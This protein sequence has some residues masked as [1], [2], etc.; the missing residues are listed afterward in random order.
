MKERKELKFVNKSENENPLFADNGSSGFDLRAWITKDDERSL[1]G[2]NGSYYIILPPLGRRMI[3]TGLYFDVPSGCEIQVRPRSG[4]AIKKGL[5][6]INTPGTLDESYIG[7]CCILGVNL[8]NESI[9][10]ENGD[11]IAQAVLCPVYNG[12]NVTLKRIEEIT[13]ET[14]RGDGGF[15]HSGTR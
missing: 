10:I 15:G 7:E 9:K 5:T 8:S 2:E 11:R 14:E 4:M 3:H 12:N 1:K 13:K 6:I